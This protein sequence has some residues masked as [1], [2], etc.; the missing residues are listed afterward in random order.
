MSPVGQALQ[1]RFGSVCRSELQ[2]L[3]KKTAALAPEHRAEV[4]A[5]TIEVAE[6]LAERLDAA[7]AKTDGE[8]DAFV[9][10]LFAVTAPDV[11]DK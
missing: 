2:R 4:H 3:H 9:M 8:L 5:L 10:R 7:V 6:R 1:E 11:E